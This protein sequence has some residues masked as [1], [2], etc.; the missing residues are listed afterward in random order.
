MPLAVEEPMSEVVEAFISKG[1]MSLIVSEIAA[2]EAAS[3]MSRLVRMGQISP[4]DGSAALADL[5]AWRL[6]ATEAIDIEAG[7]VRLAHLLVRRFET[8]LRVGDALHVAI[9]KR[10]DVHLISFNRGL[11]AAAEMLGVAYVNPEPAQI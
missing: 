10:L 6:S 7:D 4:Q 5:D 2:A 9:C 1:S 8:K 11:C 3:G